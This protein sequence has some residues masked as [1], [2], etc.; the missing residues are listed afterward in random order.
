MNYTIRPSAEVQFKKAPTIAL[1]GETGSGKTESAMR[2]ARG[3]VGPYGKFLVIDTEEKRA[4][5]KKNR[6]SFD[7]MDLQPPF[8]PDNYRGALEAAR[9]YDAVVVDS[10]S[11]EYTG[12]G[13]MQDMQAEDLERMS[14]GDAA[15]MEK[16]TAPAWKRAKLSHK[17]LMG[18]IIRYPT[19]LI[20]CLRAEPKIKF[21]KDQQG[22]TQIV[23]A[24]YVP[25]CEKMFMYEM[26]V[27]ALMHG[28]NPGVPVHLK[29]LEP[30]LEPVFLAGK[31][32]DEST[33]ERLADWANAKNAAPQA[34]SSV[35]SSSSSTTA[36]KPAEP[37]KTRTDKLNELCNQA[38]VKLGDL[39]QRAEVQHADELTEQDYTD[40]VAALQRRIKTNAARATS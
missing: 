5:Y 32:I 13:G 9:E 12:E 25:I 8:S 3:Y 26:L 4:L 1:A 22:K 2:L 14:R 36:G 34:T 11:H 33:G 38:S 29:K 7:W 31:Q 28:D 18:Q 39:L 16:L 17:K 15:R 20:V 19:L 35:A 37:I 6:Y 23:D 21:Q 27:G 40:A 10:G 24:G 30:D